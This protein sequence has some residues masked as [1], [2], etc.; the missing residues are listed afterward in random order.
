MGD[1]VKARPF[2]MLGIALAV[3]TIIGLL[4]SRR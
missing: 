3:G 2:Q 1:T 4:I